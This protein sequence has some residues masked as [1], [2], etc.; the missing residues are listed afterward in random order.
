[1]QD[2]E[3]TTRSILEKFEVPSEYETRRSYSGTTRTRLPMTMN[4]R[5][6]NPHLPEKA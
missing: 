1:M 4:S 6:S 2:I 5:I 3:K